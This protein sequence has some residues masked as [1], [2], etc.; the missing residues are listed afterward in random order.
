[1]RFPHQRR[2]F[3]YIFK[4]DWD[5]VDSI[6][7]TADTHTKKKKIQN[8]FKDAILKKVK[9]NVN[10]LLLASN[11]CDMFYMIGNFFNRRF[12]RICNKYWCEID[13]EQRTRP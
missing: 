10:I 1:M 8:Q 11:A 2:I 13:L 3:G 7:V 9:Q 4:P 6:K 12:T 5:S